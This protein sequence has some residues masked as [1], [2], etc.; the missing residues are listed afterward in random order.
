MNEQLAW[1]FGWRG[2]DG[3]SARR[4]AR[5]HVLAQRGGDGDEEVFAGF[6]WG[7]ADFAARSAILFWHLFRSLRF[8][9]DIPCS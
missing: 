3:W 7:E 6:A 2:A 8:H 5:K 4:Q 1:A 9:I